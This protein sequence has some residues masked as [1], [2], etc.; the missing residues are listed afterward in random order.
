MN[1]QIT[2]EEP[3]SRLTH[4]VASLSVVVILGVAAL[5]GC[6]S[7]SSDTTG[8]APSG[9][10][11]NRPG[12]FRIDPAEQK[13]IQKCLKAAGLAAR[14]PTGWPSEL[15]S[16]GPSGSPPS[17]SPPTDFPS[18]GFS[19]DPGGPGGGFTDPQVQA[20]LKACGITLPNPSMASS[21][22]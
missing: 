15:T 22:G 2:R 19:G 20:A 3:M 12:A 13:K 1:P 10:S 21:N 9:I 11:S 18:G 4:R 6:G 7:P 5:T 8:D 16:G 14:L 17:G